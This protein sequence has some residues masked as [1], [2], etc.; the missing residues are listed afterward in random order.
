MVAGSV[1][2]RPEPYRSAD[3]RLDVGYADVPGARLYYELA[4]RG[5]PLVLTP[6]FSLDTRMW[7]DQLTPFA[8]RY[9][10]LRYDPRG[11]G[12]SSEPGSEPYSHSEDLRA[13]LAG[14]GIDR[15]HIVGLSLGGGTA[16]DFALTYPEST[17]SL[18]TVDSTLSGFPWSDAFI[19]PIKAC[20]AVARAES[21]EAARRTWLRHPL[22][23]ATHRDERALA[24]LRRMVADYSGWHWLHRDPRQT[25]DPPALHRLARL[26]MPT[27]AIVGEHD[28]PDFHA[29]AGLVAERAPHASKVVLPGVG[30]LANMEAPEVFT[31]VVLGFLTSASPRA[32]G[33]G[34]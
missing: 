31:E 34:L 12:R 9:R 11:F 5:E 17:H 24:A 7:D 19:A 28:M 2:D 25:P 26:T 13:L 6:G 32:E 3:A 27:L 4:G 18:I 15:A 30:H 1:G 16:I 29:I 10:V 21:V 8:D 33:V 22:F 23:T 20:S 14:L